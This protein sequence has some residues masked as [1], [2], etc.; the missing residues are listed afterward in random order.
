MV[1]KGQSKSGT[2]RGT[3]ANRT[4]RTGR[5]DGT[6]TG[7]LSGTSGTSSNYPSVK[8]RNSTGSGGRLPGAE[9]NRGYE[10]GPSAKPSVRSVSA[11]RVR[12]I[13]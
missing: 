10:K 5:S 2:E 6:Q 9:V 7:A 1:P 4:N 13:G 12:K 8:S 11:S 3:S